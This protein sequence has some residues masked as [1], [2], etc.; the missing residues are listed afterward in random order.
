MKIS[1]VILLGSLC[2]WSDP[3]EARLLQLG[4]DKI[5]AKNIANGKDKN[6]AQDAD[7]KDKNKAQ[8]ANGTGKLKAQ[9][10]SGEGKVKAQNANG[11]GS[12]VA[13][14][15]EKQ[16][17]TIAAEIEPK[18]D[19]REESK[20]FGYATAKS[21]WSST[22]KGYTCA[23]IIQQFWLDVKGSVFTE[24]DSK[25]SSQSTKENLFGSCKR[26]AKKF[27][28]EQIDACFNVQDCYRLG[29]G[30]S[31][32]VARGFCN[33]SEQL[34]NREVIPRKCKSLAVATCASDAVKTIDEFF[35]SS[36]C[37]AVQESTLKYVDKIHELCRN[38]VDEKEANLQM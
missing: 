16:E 27:A 13:A 38:E 11:D 6:K 17:T 1:L 31:N 9:N 37:D 20:E 26:G 12:L 36:L 35:Q 5:K 28:M 25:W 24:C 30:A 18:L 14:G 34:M 10:A 7:G 22:G 32:S 29:V 4:K 8:N 19:Q 33:N 3:A 21:L 15:P 2:L 23:N